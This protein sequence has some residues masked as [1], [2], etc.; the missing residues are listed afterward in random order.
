MVTKRFG[1]PWYTPTPRSGLRRAE[2]S[3]SAPVAE[4]PGAG[5]S[6]DALVRLALRK[7][8]G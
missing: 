4:E 8:S 6:L 1:P 2:A 3:G 7:A 5:A